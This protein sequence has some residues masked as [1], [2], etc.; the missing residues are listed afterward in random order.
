M[1]T[2]L[3]FGGGMTELGLRTSFT[4]PGRFMSRNESLHPNLSHLSDVSLFSDP[5]HGYIPFVSKPVRP[6]RSSERDLIDSD[7]IQRLRSILQLQSAR[8]VFPSAEHSRFVHSLGAMHI[9]GRFA[10]HLYPGFNESFPDALSPSLFESLLRVS[11]LFHDSGH[12][13]FCHFYDDHVLKDRFGIS[14]ERL[15][16]EIIRGPMRGVIENLDRSPSGHF[17]SGESLSA[18]WVAYLVGKGSRQD[19]SIPEPPEFIKRLKPLFSGLFTVDNLDYI[20]RD[21]YMC[22]VSIGPIDLDRI[23]FYTRFEEK[24][25]SFHRAGLGALEIFLVIRSFM[26]QQIY[27]HRTTRLFDMSLEGVLGETVDLLSPGNPLEHLD[28]YLCLTD[29]F[30]IESVRLWRKDP[31]PLRKALGEKWSSFLSRKKQW[32][33]VYESEWRAERVQTLFP[34]ELSVSS[35][36][37][38]ICLSLG[39]SE[40]DLRIDIASRDT[41]PENPSDFQKR[42]LLVWD[43]LLKTLSSD[44]M[45]DLLLSLP[46]RRVMVRAFI[47]RREGS[48]SGSG[49]LNLVVKESLE[50]LG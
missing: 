13:P 23:L 45:V 47:Q 20:L 6:D 16:Q 33:L 1:V 36:E 3:P 4:D 19:L 15:S 18:D 22:G 27:F 14:H 37:K 17:L 46:V 31:N 25:L 5:I 48:S 34:E 35:R 9:A 44:P 29:H 30:L 24:Y 42:G 26:Y 41:R 38:E 28:D 10:A 50:N 2:H 8:L 21:S 40:G 12:G 32:E 7:W 43:P 11:A 49:H 39:L